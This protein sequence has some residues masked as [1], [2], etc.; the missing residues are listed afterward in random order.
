MLIGKSPAIDCTKVDTHAERDM[1]NARPKQP[2]SA[3]R[4]LKRIRAARQAGK[5][6]KVRW[7]VEEWLRSYQ[8]KRLA[9]RLA[10][11]KMPKHCRP[12]KSELDAIAKALDPWKGSGE[13]AYVGKQA[14]EHKPNEYRLTIDFGIENRALQYLLL[15]V[16]REA[17]ELHPDQYGNR[18]GVH[19]AIKRVVEAMNAGHLWAT[20]F[21]IKNCF[22]SFDGKKALN[23]L[24]VPERVGEKV[25]LTE[26][27]SLLPGPTLTW[28]GN[29]EADVEP[30]LL[31]DALDRVRQG[32]PE[33][34]A[35]SSFVVEALL[36]N[37]I[38][39]ISKIGVVVSYID[40]ILLL[41]KTK[42]DLASMCQYLRS[43][44]KAHPAGPFCVTSKHFCPGG[45]IDFLGHRL[46]PTNGLIR[47]DPDNRNRQKLQTLLSRVTSACASLKEGT[48][49]ALTRQEIAQRM[50]REVTSQTKWLKLCDGIGELRLKA[51]AELEEAL[52]SSEE[53]NP[54]NNTVKKTFKL[55][56]DQKE[57]VKAALKH[58]K[59]YTGIPHDSVALELICQSYMGTGTAFANLE[60]ALTAECKKSSSSK[61]FLKKVIP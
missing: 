11:R 47:I 33:G 12:D 34:S 9:V 40:N 3:K 60:A 31:D 25:L 29:S 44:L 58:A 45:P 36:A 17:M 43:A 16:L 57:I 6:K 1:A 56:D 55:H 23:L 4:L 18:G 2:Y 37:A 46:T 24:P 51:L 35:A 22:S 32:L 5:S 41:A 39:T 42:N 49:P 15:I 54:M 21:D 48:L 53:K 59:E 38:H 13:V 27:L 14:K 20:E 61:E 30:D 52:K 10:Y 8:A 28:V 26:H 19:R 7:L 50:K